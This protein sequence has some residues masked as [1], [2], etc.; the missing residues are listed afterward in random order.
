M[1]QPNQY[2]DDLD[3][4][5]TTNPNIQFVRL[6]WLDYVSTLRGRVLVATHFRELIAS[7]RFHE[8]GRCFVCLP[9]DSGPWYEKDPTCAVGKLSVVPDL[10]SLRPV[11]GYEGHASV[12]CYLGDEQASSANW[13]GRLCVD[14]Q[15]QG[16][17]KFFQRH[18]RH[19]RTANAGS[20]F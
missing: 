2:L 16:R 20:S 17:W 18:H 19:A 13:R 10:A 4:F 8:V 11:P 14:A 9:D 1:D 7:N 3:R 6:V 12:F 15:T 5:L